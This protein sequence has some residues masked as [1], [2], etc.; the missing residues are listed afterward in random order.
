MFLGQGA[1]P[2]A[3]PYRQ[4]AQFP[5]RSSIP[6]PLTLT[7]ALEKLAGDA[8]SP[9]HVSARIA[10]AYL[11]HDVVGQEDHAL[12]LL[13]Q[14]ITESPSYTARF[15]LTA[16]LARRQEYKEAMAV[17]DGIKPVPGYFE[18]FWQRGRKLLQ[19]ADKGE[20]L[21]ENQHDIVTMRPKKPPATVAGLLADLQRII[22][23]KST[24]PA[25]AISD[26]TDGRAA[27]LVCE[28]PTE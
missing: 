3:S 13:R 4:L 19:R 9:L 12:D 16:F 7:P 27:G 5:S 20:P 15:W 10:E 23:A 26:V 18:T 25:G 21:F 17:F 2:W 1:P 22:D 6:L 28:C 24:D 14:T 11:L 8:S